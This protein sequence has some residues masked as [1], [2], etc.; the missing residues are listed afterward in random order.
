M[1][2]IPS[3]V[4]SMNSTPRVLAFARQLMKARLQPIPIFGKNRGGNGPGK[5]NTSIFQLKRH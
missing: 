1:S 3:G 4:R 5:G 2:R